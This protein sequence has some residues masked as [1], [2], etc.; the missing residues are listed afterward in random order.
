MVIPQPIDRPC[1]LAHFQVVSPPAPTAGPTVASPDT[2]EGPGTVAFTASAITCP[3]GP[4]NS[5]WQ[6][7]CQ[8]A[9]GGGGV[10]TPFPFR[11]GSVA[12]QSA[13]LINHTKAGADARL[14]IGVGASFDMDL[15]SLANYSCTA[16]LT[17]TDTATGLSATNQST[18]AVRLG[19]VEEGRVGI[20]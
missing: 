20:G 18:F 2:L 11:I 16:E 8:Q 17:V 1:H 15:A 7:S 14:S 9:E 13:R 3:R 12:G 6:V 19:R 10:Q 4:C 5:T